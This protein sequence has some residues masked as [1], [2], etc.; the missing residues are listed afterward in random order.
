MTENTHRAQ[1]NKLVIIDVK[2]V[3]HDEVIEHE[4][5]E[6]SFTQEKKGTQRIC[7]ER[8]CDFLGDRSVL[9]DFEGKSNF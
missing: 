8:V 5:S 3:T 9:N 1:L 7:S 6:K 2:Y 4:P